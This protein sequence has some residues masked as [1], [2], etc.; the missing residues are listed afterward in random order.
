MNRTQLTSRVK[1]VKS[2]EHWIWTINKHLY[3]YL[4][5]TFPVRVMK[6]LGVKTLVATNACGGLNP[7]YDVGD[8]MIMK[9]HINLPGLCGMNPL[10]GQ[11]DER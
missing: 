9:D 1:H 3:L 10:I 6:L 11:N 7:D 2:V 5:L 4:Q 8:V